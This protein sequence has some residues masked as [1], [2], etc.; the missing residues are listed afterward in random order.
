M[1]ELIVF[2]DEDAEIE[3]GAATRRRVLRNPLVTT[4]AGVQA[5][6]IPHVFG[7]VSR[8]LGSLD[9]FRDGGMIVA[10]G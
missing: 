1:D 9:V 10:G 3:K 5:D 8:R 2:L 4:I 6:L 7:N